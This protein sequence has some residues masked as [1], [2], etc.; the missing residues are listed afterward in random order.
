MKSNTNALARITVI[1]CSICLA[2]MS[3]TS[4]EDDNSFVT[5]CQDYT[6]KLCLNINKEDY[7]GINSKERTRSASND[8]EDGDKLFLLFTTDT[9]TVS[10]T[11]TYSKEDDWVLKYNGLLTR[12][13]KTNVKVFYFTN[14]NSVNNDSLFFDATCGIYT[15]ETGVYFYPSDATEIRI[16]ATLS[17]IT[18][19]VKFNDGPFNM[20]GITYYSSFDINKGELSTSTLPLIGIDDEYIYGFFPNT[21]ER[22]IRIQNDKYLF[23]A[24]CPSYFLK[25]GKSG[26]LDLP[27]HDNH[28]GW[29]EKQV[30]GTIYLIDHEGDSIYVDWVDFGLPS[31][32]KWSDDDFFFEDLSTAHE[33]YGT[34]Y[35]TDGERLPWGATWFSDK[36]KKNNYS[37]STS[38]ISG[39]S[40]DPIWFSYNKKCRLPKQTEFQELVDCLI[41]KNNYHYNSRTQRMIYIGVIG[42]SKE[43]LTTITLYAGGYDVWDFTE[44]TA[45]NNY[46]DEKGY[47]WTSTPSSSS[48][49]YC[50]GF[51]EENPVPKQYTGGKGLGM[52]M[53]P[54]INN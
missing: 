6:I 44:W 4:D 16:N 31:G 34:D 52:L 18:G 1:I 43:N 38:D 51:D 41:W 48:K 40:N 21:S 53:R 32:L 17:P 15:D 9:K 20:D 13:Q 37:T 33:E 28:N 8:W 7:D 35:Y 39:T 42:Y 47:Y 14:V 11:A 49:A 19:R 23:T 27:T 50:F 10:G 45:E 54:V 25:K 30:G 26:Y 5:S 24:E 3:C 29:E 12:D 2:F 46:Y 22:K 36:G